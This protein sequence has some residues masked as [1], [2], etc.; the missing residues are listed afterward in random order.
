[1]KEEFIYEGK[2]EYLLV[3]SLNIMSVEERIEMLNN[4]VKMFEALSI[5]MQ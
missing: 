1:M 4:A 3:S 2:G 5:G